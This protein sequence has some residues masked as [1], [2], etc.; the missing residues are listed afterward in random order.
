MKTD[1]FL[2]SEAARELGVAAST[3]RR[4]EERGTLKAIRTPGGTRI[5]EASDVRKL[6]AQRE[7]REGRAQ[8]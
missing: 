8:N 3:I 1:F 7:R 5:F 2:V 6:A 4:L